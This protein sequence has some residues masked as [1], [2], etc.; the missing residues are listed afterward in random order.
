MAIYDLTLGSTQSTEAA[1]SIAALPAKRRSAYMVEA[2]LDL[3]KID[4]Y[5]FVSGDIFQ[6]LEIPANTFVVAAGAEVLTAFNGTS[7]VVDI[8]FAEGDDIVDGAS[9]ASTGYL[10][11]GTNGGA[12]LTSQSTFVQIV[13]T[14]DTIDVVLTA[15]AA[16]VT[17]GK[18]RVYAIVVDVD[19]II[20]AADEVDRD[21]LA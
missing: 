5:T 15:G 11:A 9:V 13:T 6:V 16:D 17:T 19:G 14:T 1:D 2:I 12:N 18:L 7:P 20:E 3:S 4:N 10:A 8:D 21:Q